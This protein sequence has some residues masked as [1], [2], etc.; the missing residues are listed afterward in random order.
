MWETRS[1][2]QVEGISFSL[3]HD[4]DRKHTPCASDRLRDEKAIHMDDLAPILSQQQHRQVLVVYFSAQ[5]CVLVQTSHGARTSMGLVRETLHRSEISRFLAFPRTFPCRPQLLISPRLSSGIKP[6]TDGCIL[7][8][9]PIIERSFGTAVGAK[10]T[11]T[12][13]YL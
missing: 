5:R 6:C 8:V 10:L 7:V 11:E 4:R 9:V 2:Q 1:L 13:K 12:G 3:S